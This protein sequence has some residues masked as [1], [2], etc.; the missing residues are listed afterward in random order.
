M[1]NLTIN[2]AELLLLG[3][4]FAAKQAH[5]NTS[6]FSRE[7]RFLKRPSCHSPGETRLKTH[8]AQSAISQS[9]TL[10]WRLDG[11]PNSPTGGPRMQ[12]CDQSSSG[13]PSSVCFSINQ[14]L[15]F[16][17]WI[18]VTFAPFLNDAMPFFPPL[19]PSWVRCISTGRLGHRTK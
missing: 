13:P 15:A 10:K 11:V 1:K 17:E 6:T 9:L 3:K 2:T 8:T 5:P 18:R 7:A 12:L 16:Q 19:R 4:M 14:P